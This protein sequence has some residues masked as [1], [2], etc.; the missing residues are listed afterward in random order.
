M[1]VKSGIFFT[2]VVLSF[3]FFS[4]SEQHYYLNSPTYKLA[5][6]SLKNEIFF[7]EPVLLFQNNDLQ[8]QGFTAINNLPVLFFSAD[9][10][11]KGNKTNVMRRDTV[12]K[13][14]NPAQT[15]TSANKKQATSSKDTIINK[16]ERD[17]AKL[18]PLVIAGTG[19]FAAGIV[20][21]V[22]TLTG[23]MIS[24]VIPLVLAVTGIILITL[25]LKKIK[26]N[27]AKY[28]GDKLAL[29]AYYIL[30]LIAAALIFYPVWLLFNV[31]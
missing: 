17:T 4:C 7:S 24:F 12:L 1:N 23:P 10:V 15:D 8:P 13:K 22:L 11:K 5:D 3:I 25:G 26:K 19:L 29:A 31:I 20:A 18:H 30:A 2:V 14:D 6:I 21:G 9:T 28:K 16:A 27:P